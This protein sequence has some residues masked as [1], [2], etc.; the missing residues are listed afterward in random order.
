MLAPKAPQGRRLALVIGND[1]YVGSPLVNARTDARTMAQALRRLAFDVTAIEDG[2]RAS[3]WSALRAFSGRLTASDLALVFYAGHGVQV[4]GNNYLIPVDFK[5]R[6]EEEVRFNAIS[7]N[8]VER[9]LQRARIGVLVLDACRNNPFSGERSGSGGLARVDVQGL[10]VAYAAGAGQTASDGPIGANGIYTSELVQVLGAPGLG[11]R[12]TFFEVQRRVA[13]RTNRRQFPAIYSQLIDDVVLTPVSPSSASPSLRVP[14]TSSGDGNAGGVRATRP[15]PWVPGVLWAHIPAGTFE[16]GCTPGD[17]EC[18]ENESPRHS[19]VISKAFELMTTE[20]TLAT[21]KAVDDDL[22][23]QRWTRDELPVVN[24]EWHRALGLCGDI[25][26]R[27]PTEAEWEYAARGGVRGTKYPWGNER[28]VCSFGRANGARFDDSAG[29]NAVGS[30]T[31]D[32]GRYAPNGYGLYD[33]A[34]NAAEW[35][36]DWYGSYSSAPQIDPR[37]P[38]SGSARVLRGG[39][40]EFFQPKDLRVSSR[41]SLP[42][43]KRIELN[44]VGVRCARDIS[45]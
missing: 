14:L 40:W 4:E 11:L 34:G 8:E 17:S 21:A 38:K 24:L 19:V 10:L 13:A 2:S 29:C 45:Q 3:M 26:A 23:Q 44:N 20:V 28:P 42:P 6:S 32:V 12:E 35:V 5:G 31:A 22:P 9:A 27:L 39:A 30:G 1:S 16:M 7:S 43:G 25:R 15:D 37:G 41:I 36:A 18:Y 33:M